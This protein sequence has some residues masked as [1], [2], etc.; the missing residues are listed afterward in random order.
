MKIKFCRRYSKYVSQQHCEF[1]NEGC[2]CQAGS[3]VHWKSIKD[4]LNDGGRPQW[5]VNAIIKPFNCRLT[6][7]KGAPAVRKIAK[8]G[9]KG[10]W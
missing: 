8:A 4:L 10:R 6:D 7:R 1:F 2:A 5:E 9:M 3:S